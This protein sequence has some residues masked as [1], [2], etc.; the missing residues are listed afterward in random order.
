[1]MDS[2]IKR[3]HMHLYIYLDCK[4]PRGHSQTFEAF[5]CALP[6]MSPQMTGQ[7]T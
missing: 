7:L 5:H 1:M 2:D 6:T 3:I 4:V